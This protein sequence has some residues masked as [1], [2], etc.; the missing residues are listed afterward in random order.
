MKTKTITLAL[1]VSSRPALG[2]NCCFASLLYM[3]VFVYKFADSCERIY[4]FFT[5]DS[6]PHVF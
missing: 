1:L 3:F 2:G 4:I 5:C 6:V